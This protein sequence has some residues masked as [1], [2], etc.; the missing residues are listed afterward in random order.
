MF[1]TASQVPAGIWGLGASSVKGNVRLENQDCVVAFEI[2]AYQV[3]VVADGLGGPKHGRKAAL[4]AVKAAASRIMLTLGSATD[5]SINDVESVASEAVRAAA[6]RLSL[7][8]GRKDIK[9][10]GL[11]TTLIVVVGNRQEIGYAYIGDGGGCIYRNGG[12]VLH[13]LQPQKADIYT[14]NVLA[15]SLGPVTQGC[16]VTG[17]IA[18]L[19]GDLVVIGTDGVFDRLEASPDQFPAGTNRFIRDLVVGAAN[20]GGDLQVVTERVLLDLAEMKDELGFVFTDNMSCGML[21]TGIQPAISKEIMKNLNESTSK[22]TGE[23]IGASSYQEK[24]S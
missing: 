7:I 3:L 19:E 15:A 1:P 6:R 9:G 22:S 23:D 21:G 18:R 13:F 10:D 20:H 24:K 16:P 17:K 8:G 2:G 14:P 11:R 5:D 4:A 12:K